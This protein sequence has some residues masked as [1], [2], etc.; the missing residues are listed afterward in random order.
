MLALSLD[1]A[2]NI[3]VGV[4]VAFVVGAVVSLWIMQ[5]IVQKLAV[6]A[7]LGLLAFA[8]WSQRTALQDCADK[9]QDSFRRAG[10]DVSVVDTECTFF[11]FTVTISD[12][13]D[14][15]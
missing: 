12:P 13:R 2:T 6:F 8:V 14:D 7:V 10:T 9:V 5:S 1:T 3:A 15:G 4:A 11:G